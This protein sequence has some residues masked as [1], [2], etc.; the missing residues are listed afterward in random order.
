MHILEDAP[1][2][3]RKLTF[4]PILNICKSAVPLRQIPELC[5]P[6]PRAAYHLPEPQSVLVVIQ[7]HANPGM[8]PRWR[9][10]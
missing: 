10:Q 5:R 8:K 7:Q 4:W 1:L 2:Y 6:L 9:T 3:G